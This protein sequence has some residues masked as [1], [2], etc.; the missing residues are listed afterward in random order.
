ML[1]N[2]SVIFENAGKIRSFNDSE[3]AT[4]KT[5]GPVDIFTER[6]NYMLLKSQGN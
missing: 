2:L 3:A 6:G 5:V 4:S 1:V